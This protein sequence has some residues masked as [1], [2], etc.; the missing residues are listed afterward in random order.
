MQHHALRVWPVWVSPLTADAWNAQL[1]PRT[2]QMGYRHQAVLV[3]QHRPGVQAPLVHRN[4]DGL[5]APGVIWRSRRFPDHCRAS[6]CV[7]SPS[8]H[9]MPP[10]YADIDNR[11]SRRPI[12]VARKPKYT[13]TSFSELASYHPAF[14]ALKKLTQG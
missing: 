3:S 11:G 14:Q 6:S 7:R 2:A 1:I 5:A 10:Q 9:I 8:L 12:D 13:A 4:A